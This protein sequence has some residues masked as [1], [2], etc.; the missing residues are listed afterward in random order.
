MFLSVN[1]YFN[2]LV[3]KQ[4]EVD[5][6]K[7]SLNE[8]CMGYSSLLFNSIDIIKDLHELNKVKN[9]LFK[10]LKDQQKEMKAKDK[11]LNELRRNL[12]SLTYSNELLINEL[13]EQ[14]ENL[15]SITTENELLKKEIPSPNKLNVL[16]YKYNELGE[17][18]TYYRSLV[19][20]ELDNLK[21]DL[22]K[23]LSERDNLKD[24]LIKL[25][26]FII[27]FNV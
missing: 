21:Y 22:S 14:K 19:N 4:N 11:D 26:E 25:R 17:E 23:V 3:I 10:W 16:N 20:S 1:S 2:N 7:E 6:F 24:E 15:N 13:C 8:L 5:R 27:Q 18:F 9:I 12:N